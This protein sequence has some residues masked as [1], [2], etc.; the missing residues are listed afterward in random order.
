M[1]WEWRGDIQRPSCH[2]R[3]PW[4]V[5]LGHLNLGQHTVSC[6]SVSCE[7]RVYL[8]VVCVI[9]ML[10]VLAAILIRK[11]PQRTLRKRYRKVYE[12]EVWEQNRT[13]QNATTCHRLYALVTCQ[14]AGHAHTHA[15]AL[16]ERRR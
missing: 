14:R 4:L 5:L 3:G 15:A 6:H 13:E 2:R 11:R 10:V 12:F 7:C 8:Q 16:R 9:D 1:D